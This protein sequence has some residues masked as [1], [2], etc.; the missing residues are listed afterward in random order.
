MTGT[1]IVRGIATVILA[2]LE[3]TQSGKAVF[4]T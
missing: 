3:T 1:G 2:G 4:I